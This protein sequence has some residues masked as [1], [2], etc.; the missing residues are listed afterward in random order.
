MKTFSLLS[1]LI[2]SGYFANS[3]V[4]LMAGYIKDTG[5]SYTEAHL[6][7]WNA[8]N[9]VTTSDFATPY[10]TFLLGSN[11]FDAF[12]S[13][14]LF[15][16]NDQNQT[17]TG[18]SSYSIQNNTL[19]I[20]SNTTEINGSAEINMSNGKLYAL[21][22]NASNISEFVEHN[23]LTNTTVT[24]G[25]FGTDVQTMLA[26]ATCYNSNT[27]NYYFIA[28]DG[29]NKCI[30]TVSNNP[31][32]YTKSILQDQDVPLA[33]NLEFD[34]TTNTLIGIGTYADT[35]GNSAAKIYSINPINGAINILTTLNTIAYY[36]NGSSTY[37]QSN[38][39]IIFIGIDSNLNRELYNYSLATNIT[40][41]LSFP[42]NVDPL[43]IYNFECDNTEFA[44]TKYQTPTS[45]L[46]FTKN[47]NSFSIS[48][49]P[50]KGIVCFNSSLKLIHAKIDVFTLTGQIIYSNKLSANNEINLSHL[51]KGIYFIK[52]TDQS[53]SSSQKLVL[54]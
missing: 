7:R 39:S 48:P 32:S 53:G 34:N 4:K 1:I 52:L 8:Q 15:R 28:Y 2:L 51:Q 40:T 38:S 45:I 50:S 29:I 27:S 37:D 10:Y 6:I 35:S 43:S 19:N 54:E 47:T 12:N 9:A 41:N 20:V 13:N 24:L 25:D 21:Y 23:L 31:F 46:P 3:Q 11:V 49:N 44:A 18:Y 22:G 33:T 16:G 17:I 26:D 30:Y 36:Q 5:G 14:Y 42:I